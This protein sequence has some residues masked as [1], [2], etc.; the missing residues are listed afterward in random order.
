MDNVDKK[1]I[2]LPS[3]YINALYELCDESKNLKKVT[4]DFEKFVK[5]VDDNKNLNNLLFS[6]TVGKTNQGRI[7]NEIL[8]KGKADKLTLN[9][10]G[11]LCRN[12][13]VNLIT[14][15]MKEFLNEV[16]RRRGEIFVEVFSPYKLNKVEEDD[17]KKIILNKTNG[18]NIS[19]LT[20]I[21]NSLLGGL[22]I[23]YGSKMIDT[24]IKTKLNNLELAMK[25]AN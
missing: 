11:V 21:D 17:L 22:I 4:Q 16:A 24:S 6:P 20:H 13:R 5:L 8:K 23:K 19:L 7:L 14:K 12:G 3:R 25:G 1:N 2:G 15:M 18:K 9:F 10:C